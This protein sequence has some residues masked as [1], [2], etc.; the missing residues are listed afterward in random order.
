MEIGLNSILGESIVVL[1]P[2]WPHFYDDPRSFW[3]LSL[4]AWAF[5]VKIR[6]KRGF[7]KSDQSKKDFFFLSRKA[8]KEQSLSNRKKRRK[9]IYVLLHGFSRNSFLGLRPRDISSRFYDAHCPLLIC[10]PFLYMGYTMYLVNWH[11]LKKAQI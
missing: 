4:F 1:L 7:P 6:G 5:D 3:C 8:E 11:L 9:I 2:L 10:S